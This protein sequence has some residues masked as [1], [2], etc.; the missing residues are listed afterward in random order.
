MAELFEGIVTRSLKNPHPN[1]TTD[2]HGFD[3]IME[4]LQMIKAKIDKDERIYVG[5]TTGE[6]KGSIAYVKEYDEL[7]VNNLS[8]EPHGCRMTWG[9]GGRDNWGHRINIYGLNCVLGWEK[10]RNK[11]Q[12]NFYKGTVF[13]PEYEGPTVWK[14][15]DKKDAVGFYLLE[16]PP[17]DRDGNLLEKGDRVIYINAR[18]GEGACLDR[19]VITEIKGNVKVWGERK[20]YETR[21]FI[22]NDEG[23]KSKIT[24]PELAI[25][26][27]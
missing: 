17:K 10:R 24:K 9:A 6:R 20:A 23:Q 5:I 19:G 16:N 13:L 22:D 2:K 27:I 3:E 8:E 25:V 1:G 7:F 14:K 15:F 11:I 12:W 26:K 18:Y 4:T 21:V